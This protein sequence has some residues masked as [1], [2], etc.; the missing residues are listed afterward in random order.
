MT[1]NEARS[2]LGLED[3]EGGDRLIGNG[4]MLNLKKLIIGKFQ[5]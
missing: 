5:I 1:P 3:K 4:A 2:K